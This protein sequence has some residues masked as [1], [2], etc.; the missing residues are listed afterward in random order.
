MQRGAPPVPR[1]VLPRDGR[2]FGFSG[3]RGEREYRN[4]S[5]N[6]YITEYGEERV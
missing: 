4:L 3:R 2:C 6:I 5:E 1:E